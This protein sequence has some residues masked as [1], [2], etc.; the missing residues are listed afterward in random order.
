M[1]SSLAVSMKG[2]CTQV[3]GGVDSAVHKATASSAA[4]SRSSRSVCLKLHLE[5][6]DDHGSSEQISGMAVTHRAQSVLGKVGRG[7]SLFCG[8]DESFPSIPS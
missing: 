8:L 7:S 3:A 4:A 2:L 1:K 5:W 6:R